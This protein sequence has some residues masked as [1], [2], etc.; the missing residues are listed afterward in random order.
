MLLLLTRK[1]SPSMLTSL[2]CRLIEF[3]IYMLVFLKGGS[4]EKVFCH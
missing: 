4:Y 2:R 1:T 3:I